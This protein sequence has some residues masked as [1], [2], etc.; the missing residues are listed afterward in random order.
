MCDW[1]NC[2]TP[3]SFFAMR[4][5]GIIVGEQLGALWGWLEP[6]IDRHL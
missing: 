4:R 6:Q 1:P 3:E 5:D 2:E